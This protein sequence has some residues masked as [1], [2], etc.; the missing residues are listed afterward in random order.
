MGPG[1]FC[2]RLKTKFI[3]LINVEKGRSES[4]VP[5]FRTLCHSV[6]TED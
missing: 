4:A 6:C 5:I 2:V 3:F 1:L